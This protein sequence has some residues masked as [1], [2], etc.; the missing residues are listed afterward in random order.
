MKIAQIVILGIVFSAGTSLSVLGQPR[1][2]TSGTSKPPGASKLVRKPRPILIPVEKVRTV[3]KTELRLVTPTTGSLT[4]AAD[5]GANLLVEPLTNKKA[6][7]QEGT[8]SAGERGFIFNALKPGKYRVAGELAGHHPSEKEI[9]IQ[10]NKSQLLTLV[11]QPIVFSLTIKTNVA[12]GE[13]KYGAEGEPVNKVATIL[14][15]QVQL[16]LPQGKYTVE[17]RPGEFGY[18]TRAETVSLD[19]DQILELSLKRIVLS[20]ETLSPNWTR[21]GLQEW[22]I[23]AGWQE[24][25]KS[26]LVKGPGVALPRGKGYRFY[27]DFKLVSTARMSNGVALS[28]ALRASDSRNYYL[29]QLTGAK[30]DDPHMLRL[31]ILKDGIERRIKAVPIAPSA[32]RPMDAGE[33]FSVSIK[34]RGYAIEVEIG[35]TETGAS[36]TLGVL[37]DP[38]QNFEFGA[39]GIVARNQEENVIGPFIVCTKCLSD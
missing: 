2:G 27:K 16:T 38:D 23:P 22:E 33:F 32:A 39:V 13:L 10:A 5:S 11:F 35:N 12:T 15:Q 34:M 28:F 7:G 36:Y 1:G 37:T 3:V 30:S 31:Y 17:L 26:L 8:I 9:V 29:L 25:K 6:E 24:S 18:E 19:K 21:D 20:T 14:N 4:V